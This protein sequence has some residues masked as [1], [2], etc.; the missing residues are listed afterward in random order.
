[1]KTT[2]KSLAVLAVT[3]FAA[4]SA[5]LASFGFTGDSLAVTSELFTGSTGSIS[6]NSTTNFTITGDEMV[7]DSS[8]NNDPAATPPITGGTYSGWNGA[9]QNTFS[10]SYTVTGLAAGETLDITSLGADYSGGSGGLRIGAIVTGQTMPSNT[11]SGGNFDLAI[12]GAPT[13]LVNGDSVNFT[14]GV[15]DGT[16]RTVTFDNFQLT[17]TVVPEPSSSALLGLGALSLVTRRRR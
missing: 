17:G 6:L 3:T 16:N 11:A 12:V 5:T 7:F 9:G 14:F 10:F 4:H 8:Y 13:G 15:R 1:M 2:I